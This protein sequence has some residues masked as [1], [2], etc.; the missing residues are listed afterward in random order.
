M[1]EGIHFDISSTQYR[2][3]DGISQTDLKQVGISPRHYLSAITD[4][5]PEPTPDQIVGQI[6]HSAVL[7]NDFSG[8]VVSPSDYDG[9]T[10]DGKKWKASQT[11][12]IITQEAAKRIAGMIASIKN[13]PMAGRLLYGEKAKREVSAWKFHQ[14]TGLLMKARADVVTEDR[15][16]MTTLVDLKS[17]QREGAKESE[18]SKSIFNWG[19]DVQS[20]WYLDIFGASFWCFVAVEKFPP[21]AVACYTLS[22]ESIAVGRQKYESYLSSIKKCVDSGIWDAYGDE[23]KTINLPEW[24]LKK[25]RV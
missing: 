1:T 2:A 10:S 20:A 14:R 5:K 15:A 19:Y 23:L 21:Y 6:I 9:R 17:V 11:K 24:E 16:G 8:F 18:F 22:P 4:E 13:H 7:E 12:P 25:Y 3:A